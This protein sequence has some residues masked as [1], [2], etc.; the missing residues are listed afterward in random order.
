VLD[1]EDEDKGIKDLYE[2]VQEV[3]KNIELRQQE[4]SDLQKGMQGGMKRHSSAGRCLAST[5]ADED[6]YAEGRENFDTTNFGR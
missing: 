5:G 6:E 3:K 1:R 2:R 4:L